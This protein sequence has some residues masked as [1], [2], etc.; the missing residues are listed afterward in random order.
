MRLTIA[1]AMA[2]VALAISPGVGADV[3]EKPTFTKD[4]LPIFQENCQTCH[5]PSGQNMSGMVAPK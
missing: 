4:V 2:G 1:A 3:P 5:R